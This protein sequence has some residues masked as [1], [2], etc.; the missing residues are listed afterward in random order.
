M[1]MTSA[2]NSARLFINGQHVGD[3]AVTAWKGA[4]GLGEFSAG[5]QFAPFAPLFAEWSRMMHADAG[6]IS[7][8]VSDRLR[9]LE[10]AM[11]ALKCDV[12]L[13]EMQQR[14]QLTILNIDGSMI[15]WKE[16]WAAC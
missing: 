9:E 5:E 1:D 13:H 16:A 2:L 11:Y 6:L 7:D 10:R 4:W 12:L 8:D 15:E 3:I 14:R